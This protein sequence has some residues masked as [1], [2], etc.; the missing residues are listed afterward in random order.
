MPMDKMR[1]DRPLP[2]ASCVILEKSLSL[3]SQGKG[4]RESEMGGIGEQKVL[5]K[6]WLPGV[7]GKGE[8]SAVGW[9]EGI[10]RSETPNVQLEVFCLA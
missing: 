8:A 10:L 6:L 9:P 3:I 5:H 7:K 2:L 4:E 1:K